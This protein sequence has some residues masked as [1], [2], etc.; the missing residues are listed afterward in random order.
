MHLVAHESLATQARHFL[1]AEHVPLYL[2][3]NILSALDALGRAAR[4]EA[5]AQLARCGVVGAPPTSLSVA[6]AHVCALPL[7]DFLSHTMARS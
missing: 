5:A 4:G 3:A 1:D 7:V 6:F 2:H